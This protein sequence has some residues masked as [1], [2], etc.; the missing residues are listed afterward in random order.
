MYVRANQLSPCNVIIPEIVLQKISIRGINI[1]LRVIRVAVLR[2][3]PFPT[4]LKQVERNLLGLKIN[5]ESVSQS[6]E[7]IV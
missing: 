1:S 3:V 5:L 6:K 2:R 7:D 4:F